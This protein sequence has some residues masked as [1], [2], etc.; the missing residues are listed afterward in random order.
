MLEFSPRIV[1][2]MNLG[3]DLLEGGA[4]EEAFRE[5]LVAAERFNDLEESRFEFFLQ[6]RKRIPVVENLAF[7]VREAFRI[8]REALQGLAHALEGDGT[9]LAEGLQ[10]LEAASAAVTRST[11]ALE[12]EDGHTRFSGYPAVNDFIQAGLNVYGGHEAP[13]VLAGRMPLLVAFLGRAERDFQEWNEL[14]PIPEDPARDFREALEGMKEGAGAVQTF[15]DEQNSQNLLAGLHL[16]QQG[17]ARLLDSSERINREASP[18]WSSL[19]DLE[20]LHRRWEKLESGGISR[21]LYQDALGGVA[22]L[23]ETWREQLEAFHDAPSVPERVKE[24]TPALEASL[25]EA[26]AALEALRGGGNDLEAL[27]SAC[28]AF[29]A[30]SRV[31]MA[32]WKASWAEL[33]DAGNF[34][35]LRELLLGAY[36]DRVPRRYVRTACQYL[37]DRLQELLAQETDPETLEALGLQEEGFGAINEW[38]HDGDRS[39]LRTALD[40]LEAGTLRL[41]A[42]ARATAEPRQAPEL[43]AVACMKCGASNPAGTGHCQACGAYL[44]IG[45]TMVGEVSSFSFQ[46]G[47]SGS[48]EALPENLQ[49]LEA[50]V[51]SLAAHRADPEELSRTVAPMLAEAERVLETAQKSG[52]ATG[53]RAADLP[54][55]LEATQLFATGLKEM[56]LFAEDG[57]VGHLHAG[58]DQARDAARRFMGLARAAQGA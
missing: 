17:S 16:L 58:L 53:E 34:S 54:A 49:I 27:K 11:R 56:L 46:E 2:V 51:T 7:E 20:R 36:E 25:E 22:R 52:P 14:A 42:R 30:A 10:R 18:T 24:G 9:E 35:H 15:L 4:A 47:P 57:G 29:E 44:A 3:E 6:G 13:D 21:N 48:P 28:E 38:L 55:F 41:L 12:T 5:A 39:H 33:Q 1:E 43:R 50:L 40:R 37:Y 19:P 31:A 32:A 26:R 23:L 8:R 45:R